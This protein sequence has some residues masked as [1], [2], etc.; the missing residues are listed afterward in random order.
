MI[1]NIQYKI[2]EIETQT[3]LLLENSQVIRYKRKRYIDK[4]SNNFK[5]KYQNTENSTRLK[6]ALNVLY[7]LYKSKTNS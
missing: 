2:L 4:L 1:S 7:I 5:N 3:N 6:I